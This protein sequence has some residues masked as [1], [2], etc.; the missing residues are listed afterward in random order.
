MLDL[1][2]G[3]RA[4]VAVRGAIGR[5]IV[6]GAA[7]HQPLELF[8]GNRAQP[9]LLA[10]AADAHLDPMHHGS[11]EGEAFRVGRPVGEHIRSRAH[12]AAADVETNRIHR[13]GATLDI[14]EDDA[15]DRN[16]VA[17]MGVGS[18]SPRAGHPGSAWH[19]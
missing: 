13:D 4:G 14:G 9:V 11:I 7:V 3:V 12:H 2:A 1:P 15:A 5:D 8:H 19:S 18:W 16:A 6:F 10:L 17:H